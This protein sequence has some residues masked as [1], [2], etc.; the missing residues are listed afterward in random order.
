[1]GAKLWPSGAISQS[2]PHVTA[3]RDMSKN[4][5]VQLC[6]Y[7]VLPLLFILPSSRF[8]QTSERHFSKLNV[9]FSDLCQLLLSSLCD[10]LLVIDRPVT[11]CASRVA[12]LA[13]T[14]Q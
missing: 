7:Q 8:E 10:R 14:A 9:L 13:N 6:V 3:H 2:T 4:V 5:S 12:F 1:M 11:Y